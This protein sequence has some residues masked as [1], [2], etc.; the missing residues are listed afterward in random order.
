MGLIPTSIEQIIV[1]VIVIIATT[2]AQR[3]FGW[4]GVLIVWFASTVI[5][6][7]YFVVRGYN[8]VIG[9]GPLSTRQSLKVILSFL[10]R[11]VPLLGGLFGAVVWVVSMIV[12]P[13]KHV[14]L[15]EV[16]YFPF[17]VSTGKYP[18]YLWLGRYPMAVS[19]IV[20]NICGSS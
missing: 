8:Y 20:G 7:S 10:V 4:K 13:P 17:N 18:G 19:G 9:F 5:F 6:T 3:K 14:A 12:P 1:L 16:N 2:I 11:F 15:T